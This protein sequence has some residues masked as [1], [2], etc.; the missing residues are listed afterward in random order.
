[1]IGTASFG[2]VVPALPVAIYL[3]GVLVG[4]VRIDAPLPARIGLALVWPLG[5]L[6]FVVTVSILLLASLIAFP[7]VGA[8]VV[9]SALAAAA[10]FAQGAQPEITARFI[11]NMAYAI[12]D[13]RTT[14]LT[15]FPYESG[16]SVYMEYDA[17][18]IHSSTPETIALITHRHGDHW[19]RRLFEK[20]GWL[21]VAPEDALYAMAPSRV[22][23]ALPVSAVRTRFEVHPMVID[24]LP[25]PH[26][27]IGHYSYLVTWSGLRLYFTG[28][29]DD[30]SQLLEAKNIDVAFVSPWLFERVHKSGRRIDARRIVIYHQTA[31]TKA[32]A[33]CSGTCSVPMQGSTL[34]LR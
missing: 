5:P 34:Q 14:L 27:N 28:D 10:V 11:G 16:Y 24:A 4:L 19:D 13:G 3:L 32:V 20:T 6:A 33:G 17:K 8:I 22:L 9:A 18:E 7:I 31:S 2:F 12:S 30:P 25:T 26:A 21:V 1:V 15:D 23:R 29:T